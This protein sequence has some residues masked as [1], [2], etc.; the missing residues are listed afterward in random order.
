MMAL[1]QT[2][3]KND[4][5]KPHMVQDLPPTLSEFGSN[6]AVRCEYDIVTHHLRVVTNS[7]MSMVFADC[8]TPSLRVP[9]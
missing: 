4:A 3:V 9:V 6:G 2:F 5:E 8:Q 7:F 1:Q